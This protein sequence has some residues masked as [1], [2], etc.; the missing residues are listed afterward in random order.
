[1][2]HRWIGPPGVESTTGLDT[3][4]SKRS[5]TP[6]GQTVLRRDRLLVSAWWV[7]RADRALRLNATL[8]K[9]LGWRFLAASP[10]I[11]TQLIHS[12]MVWIEYKD[13]NWWLVEGLGTRCHRSALTMLQEP[14]CSRVF[15]RRC[16]GTRCNSAQKTGCYREEGVIAFL[17][18]TRA[19]L[20]GWPL[21]LKTKC[22]ICQMRGWIGGEDSSALCIFPLYLRQ[23]KTSIK[24]WGN[25]FPLFEVVGLW[26]LLS[27]I[28][29]ELFTFLW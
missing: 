11:T 24:S 9:E 21:V 14:D 1:M 12:E 2:P 5:C 6:G 18:F 16:H 25:F 17:K 20:I 8:F 10:D 7:S 22:R 15:D 29:V 3:T 19:I 4:P 13:T 23:Q 28:Y 26:S 27:V